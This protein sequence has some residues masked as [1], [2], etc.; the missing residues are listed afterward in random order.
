MMNFTRKTILFFYLL[1]VFA[2]ELASSE[3]K[4]YVI[5]LH[6]SLSQQNVELT[7]LPSGNYFAFNSSGSFFIKGQSLE[8]NVVQPQLSGNVNSISSDKY[9]F[10]K[11]LYRIEQTL[12]GDSIVPLSLR[13]TKNRLIS[14]AV[15]Y[16]NYWLVVSSDSLWLVNSKICYLVSS[17]ISGIYKIGNQLFF[18][19]KRTGLFYNTGK[20]ARFLARFPSMPNAPARIIPTSK[21]FLII[22]RKPFSAYLLSEKKTTQCLVSQKQLSFS[23]GA[24]FQYKYYLTLNNGSLWIAEISS[25]GKL[26]IHPAEKYKEKVLGVTKTLQGDLVLLFHDKMKYISVVNQLERPY[27]TAIDTIIQLENGKAFL[28]NN[29]RL[30]LF[31]RSGYSSYLQLPKEKLLSIIPEE[32]NVILITSKG[33]IDNK[34]NKL[35]STDNMTS[36]KALSSAQ[37]L[38]IF[39]NDSLRR[40]RIDGNHYLTEYSLFYPERPQQ[41]ETDRDGNLWI[42]T[43]NGLYFYSTLA[44]QF[45]NVLSQLFAGDISLYPLKENL[46][47]YNKSKLYI[48][49]FSGELIPLRLTGEIAMLPK[50]KIIDFKPGENN[51][52]FITFCYFDREHYVYTLSKTELNN[53]NL[54]FKFLTYFE[55][56]LPVRNIEYNASFAKIITANKLYKIYYPH[57]TY[58]RRIVFFPSGERKAFNDIILKRTSGKMPRNIEFKLTG[59]QAQ[60]YY[61]TMLEPL[62]KNWSSC[63]LNAYHS[64]SHLGTGVYKLHVRWC[65]TY[66]YVEAQST[67]VLWVHWSKWLS[68]YCLIV[69]FVL[70][71]ISMLFL[72]R[73]LY[74]WRIQ[75]KLDLEQI[76]EERTANLKA[77]KEKIELLLADFVPRDA[78]EEIITTGRSTYQRYENVTVLFADIQ[79]FTKIT[80]DTDPEILIR[81]L[82]DFFFCFDSIVERHGIEKI[83]TIG[84]AYMCAGG[85][86][87]KRSTSPVEIVLVAIEFQQAVRAMSEKGEIN[88]QVRIGIHTGP[89][90]AGVIGQKKLSYDIWG[91]TVNMANRMETSADT[92]RINISGTTWELVRDFFDCEYRGK[93]PIKNKGDADMYFVNSIHFKLQENGQP[94]EFFEL[95]MQLLRLNDLSEKVFEKIENQIPS[96]LYFHTQERIHEVFSRSVE[97]ARLMGLSAEQQLIL[98]TASLLLYYGMTEDYLNFL[99]RSKAYAWDLLRENFYTVDQIETVCKTMNVFNHLRPSHIEETLLL[100]S[101][102]YFLG[103]NGLEEQL[104]ALYIEESESIGR[105]AWREWITRKIERYHQVLL[106]IDPNRANFTVDPETQ[107]QKIIDLKI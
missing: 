57:K 18:W 27:T 48:C 24:F 16:G 22:F 106:V 90:I 69:Y 19:S 77:E 74:W 3:I 56:K 38:W 62:E 21:G 6:N 58:E 81:Q 70:F 54:N 47:V 4:S 105:T 39:Y 99:E 5:P 52:G 53:N 101:I 102:F 76:I 66:G 46:I 72:F 85:L 93:V 67:L 94:N 100:E 107:F 50:F 8:N 42:I 32:D 25:N 37:S 87:T 7:A 73:F 17:S 61:Q 15:K 41:I 95:N 44:N 59:N 20:N 97:S 43:S 55:S 36:S 86:P 60:G 84:D 98:E 65:N 28:L 9:F 88:W 26:S 71:V 96:T 64:L 29:N 80:E 2:G 82:D 33:L 23:S 103:Q 12:N 104:R 75:Q 34:N 10:G 89:V 51:S 83:K 35:L 63:S 68:P 1:L 45:K 31:Y 40:I 91:D 30:K 13:W 49:S 92:G 14:H 79:D 78:S 11:G